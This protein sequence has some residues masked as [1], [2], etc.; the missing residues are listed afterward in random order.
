MDSFGSSGKADDLFDFY[1][2]NADKIVSIVRLK[3]NEQKNK[4][5]N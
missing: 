3:I 5:S 2:I 4:S 1:G